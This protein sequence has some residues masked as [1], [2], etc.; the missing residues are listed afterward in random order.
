M[1]TDVRRVRLLI[2]DLD[3][4]LYD[5]VSS[6]VP[7]FYE[8]VRVA[9]GPL[10]VREE[11]L[12]DDLRVVHQRYRNSEQPFALLET[13]SVQ[14]R[15]GMMTRADQARA[16]DPAFHVFNAA[17]RKHLRS[18]PGVIA[19]LECIRKT[20]CAV[21][22]HTEAVVENIIYRLDALDL[23]RYLDRVYAPEGVG[24]V[25]PFPEQLARFN[26]AKQK[27]RA[28]PA[29]H[30]KPEPTVVDDICHDFSVA[31]SETVYVGDSLSR[32]VLMA[33]LAGAI[34]AHAEYGTRRDA[35]LWQQ[36][37][38]VTHWTEEDVQRER[39][40]QAQSMDVAPDLVL[41]EFSDLLRPY[42]TP[43]GSTR[44]EFVSH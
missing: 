39:N 22:A 18:Y 6:F 10:D 7:A 41:G 38:R 32:D 27:L 28:L 29:T 13:A 19:T 44:L 26:S 4:T 14:T 16:L 17:R 24:I 5:W 36:L 3:N 2:T 12:L 21:V 40:L 42:R 37:V 25:H 11:Q 43:N 34:A 30:R 35:Q 33:K 31:S 20:G 23:L 15:L 9:A 8:M 1:P